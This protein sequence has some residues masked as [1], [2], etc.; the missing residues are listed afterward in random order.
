MKTTITDGTLVDQAADCIVIGVDR[1]GLVGK[2]GIAVDR[3]FGGSLARAVRAKTLKSGLGDSTLVPLPGE[4]PPAMALLMGMDRKNQLTPEK[5]FRLGGKMTRQLAD[6]GVR[7]VA[8]PL[9]EIVAEVD[10]ANFIAGALLGSEG[11]ALYRGEKTPVFPEKLVFCTSRTSRAREGVVV[12]EAINLTRR[13]VNEPPNRMYPE[14]FVEAASEMAAQCGLEVEVWDEERLERERCWALLAVAR[15]AAHRPRLLMLRH[16]GGGAT[17]PPLALVGKGVT[18]DSGGLS[19]K[20]S[21]SMTDMKCDMAGAATVVG[22]MR[23]IA[24]LELPVNVYGYCGLVENMIAGNAYRLGDV[25]ETRSG[26]TIEILNTDAEGRVVLADVLNVACEAKPAGIVD[27]ATLTGACMVALGHDVVGMF[28]NT[29]RLASEMRAC[30]NKTGEL[31]WQLPMFD[32]YGELVESQVAEIKNVGA[33]RWAGAIT[34]AKF[35]EHFV[36]DKPWLHLDIAGPAFADS[37]KAYRDAGATGVMVRTLVEFV[38]GH[39]AGSV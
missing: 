7:K 20:P 3:R 14:S 34:A 33:G 29:D 4:E 9:E 1:D 36:Q 12:G 37:S 31:V 2:S 13:L 5:A 17:S 11:Q 26:K 38:R 8:V 21:E 25:I 32:H 23:A 39:A 18:F 35:L 22:A 6:S 15:A 30:A 27:L 19:L 28:T 16:R 10:E 24:Q